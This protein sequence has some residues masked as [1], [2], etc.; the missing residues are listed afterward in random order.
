MRIHWVKSLRSPSRVSAAST[1]R[2]LIVSRAASSS[3]NRFNIS[4]LALHDAQPFLIHFAQ[5]LQPRRHII[6]I[7]TLSRA[8]GW[9]GLRDAARG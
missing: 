2:V 1:R 5:V 8:L 7:R 9:L 6:V 3:S 4:L